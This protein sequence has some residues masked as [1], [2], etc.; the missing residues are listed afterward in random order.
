VVGCQ[1]PMP[2]SRPKKQGAID[3]AVS[4]R[5][6]EERSER[7]PRADDTEA[8]NRSTR[9]PATDQQERRDCQSSATNV[10]K[11]TVRSPIS[12]K[13]REPAGGLRA[14]RKR[15]GP[16]RIPMTD[17]RLSSRR[18]LDKKASPSGSQTTEEETP[19]RTN[20]DGE[21]EHSK[22]RGKPSRQTDDPRRHR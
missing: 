20:P 9:L 17:Y 4:H 21:T 3:E 19:A 7:Q 12:R 10:E 13:V 2:P 15:K 8:R 11:E 14:Q 5:W 16:S 22:S 1:P 6:G 18:L